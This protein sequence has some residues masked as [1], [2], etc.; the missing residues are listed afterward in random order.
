[1]RL[2]KYIYVITIKRNTERQSRITKILNDHSLNFSFVYGV[3][4]QELKPKVVE[5]VFDAE[6]SKKRLGYTLTKNEIACSLSHIKALKTFL[7]D[8]KQDYALI[9]EDD[10]EITNFVILPEALKQIPKIEDWDLLYFGY[11]NMNMHMPRTIY[12]KWRLIYPVLNF[13]KIKRYDLKKIRLIFG[14]RFNRYWFRAGSHNNAHAYLVSRSAAQ[15]IIDYNSPV[16]LQADVVLMDMITA[17]ELK[18]YALNKPL[19]E[20]SGTLES[21]IGARATWV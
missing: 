19:F 8:K 10:I 16:W 2:L 13:L 21:S 18:A 12:L 3:D 5:T 11:Q 17:G 15:K 20:Q 4:G 6:I 14:E 1:M 9:L 7:E